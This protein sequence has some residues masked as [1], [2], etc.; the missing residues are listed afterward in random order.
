MLLMH[1]DICAISD[2]LRVWKV[3]VLLITMGI[4]STCSLLLFCGLMAHFNGPYIVSMLFMVSSMLMHVEY[5]L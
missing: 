3:I 2:R 4:T 5:K 1:N